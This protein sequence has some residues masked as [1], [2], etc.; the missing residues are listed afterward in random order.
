VNSNNDI[1]QEMR[2]RISVANRCYGIKKQLKSHLWTYRIKNKLYKALTRPV[3][4]Y[5]SETW[6]LSK[7]DEYSYTCNIWKEDTENNLWRSQTRQ[8]VANS[9]QSGVVWFVEGYA[10]TWA[11]CTSDSIL[12]TYLSQ[13]SL[14]SFLHSLLATAPS[15]YIQVYFPQILYL[16]TLDRLVFYYLWLAKFRPIRHRDIGHP[17]RRW[18]DDFLRFLYNRN[19]SYGLPWC[20]W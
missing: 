14:C 4:I 5:A 19:R 8:W 9:I 6:V 10:L 2:K 17:Q 18:D 20:W 15:F 1:P 12:L 16:S 13:L 3:L 11:P 7:Q